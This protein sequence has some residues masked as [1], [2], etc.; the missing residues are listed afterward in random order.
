MSNRNFHV[1]S[2]ETNSLSYVGLKLN[3]P[4]RSDIF[5]FEIE[6]QINFKMNFTQSMDN[7]ADLNK[8]KVNIY[9]NP[10]SKEKF[11]LTSKYFTYGNN[12]KKD[13]IP[14]FI[15][16]AICV[17]IGAVIA[18]YIMK[19][20]WDKEN[21]TNPG[22]TNEEINAENINKIFGTIKGEPTGRTIKM[23][24]PD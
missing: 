17:L 20:R 16:V 15:I 4:G 11:T 22:D 8:L 14:F 24:E 9:L 19:K 3:V 1:E 2:Y 18:S 5:N 7:I 6:N 12:K 10:R 21:R 13:N 23:N